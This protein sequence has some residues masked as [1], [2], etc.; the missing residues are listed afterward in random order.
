MKINSALKMDTSKSTISLASLICILIFLGFSSNCKAQ[1]GSLDST[2]SDDGILIDEIGSYTIS[3]AIDIAL[4]ADGKLVIV[5]HVWNGSTNDIAVTRYNSDGTLDTSFGDDGIKVFVLSSILSIMSDI[6]IQ[7]DGKILIAG[8]MDLGVGDALDMTIIRLNA[9]GN[10]D[11]S[12]S[13]DGIQT[14]DI[15]GDAD[16]VISLKIQPDG[17]ILAAGFTGL[18]ESDFALIR[19]LP[20]GNLDS[21]FNGTGIVTYNFGSS[22]DRGY[23]VDLMS[24]GRIILAGSMSNGL[25]ED[26]G[27]I[28]YNSNGTFDNTFS[29]DGISTLT[30]SSGN[31]NCF[32]LSIQ[33]DG[34]MV[35]IGTAYLTSS[36]N[37]IA[38]ARLNIDGSLDNTFSDDGIQL[39]D[40]GNNSDWGLDLVIQPNGQI[41]IAGMTAP[42]G[43]TDFSLVRLQSNGSLDNSFG[44][45]GFVTTPLNTDGD[46]PAAMALQNDGKVILVGQVSYESV[47]AVK[48]AAVRY[49][50]N[51]ESNVS[52]P[53]SNEVIEPII[54]PSPCQDQI[55][56]KL[57]ETN[58]TNSIIYIY[59]SI[60]QIVM[61]NQIST[62]ET[63][64]KFDLPN[65]FYTLII[66]NDEMKKK[67][68]RKFEVFRN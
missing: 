55:T 34:K 53:N 4:S 65:G 54:Y 59:N 19:L 38:A 57:N 67:Y 62:N 32:G 16:Y 29:D 9:D 52:I 3:Q 50:G 66:L 58:Y 7:A 14:I 23:A 1:A 41:L 2:F 36:T 18:T 60:G 5:G 15:N 13:N 28:R 33:P 39:V 40:L 42:Q 63:I 46:S 37:Q 43:Y 68:S 12:F 20:N 10:L 26:L 22:Y 31:D 17:K 27:I 6:Q 8:F 51:S 44:I 45:G 47:D 21:S 35:L 64:L 49:L 30:L 24:D 11:S 48:L 56:I 61:Q 25:S